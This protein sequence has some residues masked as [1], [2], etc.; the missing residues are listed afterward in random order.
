MSDSFSASSPALFQQR[1]RLL[2][3]CRRAQH[4]YEP[5]STPQLN[6]LMSREVLHTVHHLCAQHT[7]E[8]GS[9]PQLSVWHGLAARQGV[10][11]I[12]LRLARPVCTVELPRRS[13]KGFAG[14]TWSS[15]RSMGAPIQ[16][17]QQAAPCPP[18]RGHLQL[19]CKVTGSVNNHVCIVAAAEA[20]TT[21]NSNS[22]KHGECKN[23]N[24]QSC[25]SVFCAVFRP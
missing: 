3:N 13:T 6:T 22:N 18:W 21:T 15:P 17:L 25:S 1:H 2:K 4:T 16:A 14:T 11:Q 12:E 7:Y 20:K 23:K 8:P 24:K 5:G 19:S 10:A 9:T